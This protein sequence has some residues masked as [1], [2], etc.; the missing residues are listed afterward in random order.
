MSD[1]LAAMAASSR[2]R[3]DEAAASSGESSVRAG[4]RA[5]APPRPLRLSVD[6]F[7]LIAEPKLASPS[8][9]ELV[10]HADGREAVLGVATSL[11]QSG[12]AALSV[13]TEP[14]V[15]G[16]AID[17]LQAA[18]AAVDV[19]VMRKDFLV[20]PIQVIE[21][22]AAGASGVLLIA[23]ILDTSLLVEM[24]DLALGMGMFALV[25]VFDEGDLEA[26]G[27]VFDREVLVGVN[28]RDLATLEVDRGRHAE[29][30]RLLPG[31]LPAVAESG[32]VSPDDAGAAAA[33]GYRVALV[34]TAVVTSEDPAGAVGRLIAAGRSAVS[35]R[36]R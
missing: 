19:P 14:T 28:A 31:H 23:R 1:F 29:M 34:G 5:A 15:F 27:A 21:A 22:R 20:D 30:A 4:A 24:T 7:D 17:H 9:G 26:A 32:I 18:A 25:E 3:A 11:E 16:G 12:C 2:L 8:A 6:G 35:A 36:S 13:L 33:A 10:P